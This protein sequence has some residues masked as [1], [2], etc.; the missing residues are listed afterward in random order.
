MRLGELGL[1]VH[2]NVL[3]RGLELEFAGFDV[4]EDFLQAGFDLGKLVLSAEQSRGFLGAGVGDRARDVV[5]KQAPVIGDG[6]AE[7]LDERGGVLSESAFP[8]DE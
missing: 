1:D 3:E 8:H 5:R 4:G 2:V 7:L 6:L